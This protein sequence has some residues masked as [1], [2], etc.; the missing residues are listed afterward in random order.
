[1]NPATRLPAT[2]AGRI[3]PQTRADEDGV[4]LRRPRDANGG[5]AHDDR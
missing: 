3:T 1:V 5:L 2:P 4:R